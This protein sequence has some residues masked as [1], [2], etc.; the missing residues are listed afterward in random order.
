M[1]QMQTIVGRLWSMTHHRRGPLPHEIESNFVSNVT[2][3]L[4]EQRQRSADGKSPSDRKLAVDMQEL[5][6]K[7][8]HTGIGRTLRGERHV[9]LDEAEAFAAVL[10]VPIELLR[11]DPVSAA[12]EQFRDLVERWRVA[13]EN[14]EA[15]LAQRRKAFELVYEYLISH[16]SAAAALAEAPA[17]NDSPEY[18]EVAPVWLRAIASGDVDTVDV[19]R[20]YLEHVLRAT[21]LGAPWPD[22][23]GVADGANAA[24]DAF[25]LHIEQSRAAVRQETYYRLTGSSDGE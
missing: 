5:G 2:R 11:L 12:S 10:G 14:W 13:G 9:K 25:R 7:I 8:D 20:H 1:L 17:I 3:I 23:V 18:S 6:I 15:S 22:Q 24:A 19:D 16:P 21:L 4:T